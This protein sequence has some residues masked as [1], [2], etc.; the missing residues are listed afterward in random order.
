MKILKICLSVICTLILTVSLMLVSGLLLVRGII[1][2]DTIMSIILPSNN[3]G[4]TSYHVSNTE[5]AYVEVAYTEQD[6]ENV[7]YDQ[8]QGISSNIDKIHEILDSIFI[9]QGLPVELIDYIVEDDEYQVA[10]SEYLEQY[11]SYS[12]GNGEKPVIDQ[13]R[14]NSILDKNITK[15]EEDTGTTVNSEK[16]EE[17]IVKMSEVIDEQVDKITENSNMKLILNFIFSKKI[18]LA[19]IV[20]AVIWLTILVVLNL[21]TNL[22]YY[23]GLT[24]I[25]HGC[26]YL[27]FK[28]I[29]NFLSNAD[30]DINAIIGTISNVIFPRINLYI[31]LSFVI[32]VILIG[33]KIVLNITSKKK[34]PELPVKL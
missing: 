34:L 3:E 30:A 6:L 13:A 26:G 28:M 7:T 22:L 31:I 14:I 20:N 29:L 25:F 15:Y 24:S 2:P 32:G 19:L 27:T 10:L 16:A 4:E 33:I 9:D 23:L 8:L 11:L 5:L 21:N 18:L 17:L 12:T 1:N